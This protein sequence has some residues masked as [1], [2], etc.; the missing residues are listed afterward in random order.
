MNIKISAYISRLSALIII[1]I[2]SIVFFAFQD[3][4]FTLIRSVPCTSS[5]L[6]TDNLGNAYL[7][8]RNVLEKYDADGNLVKSFSNKSM[9]DISFAD[10][11]DPLKILLFYKAFQQIVFTDNM[12]APSG[13]T[14]S[15]EQLDYNQ[16]SL[17]CTS[18]NNGFWIYSQQNMELV[19]FDQNLQKSL[20]TGNI[21]QLSGMSI[22]PN[23]LTEQN[24]NVF[25]NDSANG[26]LVFDIYG[27]YSKT[28]PIKGL[29]RFQVSNDD[30]LYLSGNK[31]KSYNMKTL[32][33]V[34]IALPTGEIIDARTGKEKLYL[35]KQKSLDIYSVKK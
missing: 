16:T 6:T 33:E 19:R 7:I 23:F 5:F 35:L 9:A 14:I 25:L 13:N 2:A 31:L 18:H 1:G 4:G 34:E 26:I 10:A 15:L 27:T 3:S 17:V 8:K 12:L 29:L 22:N 32:E 24:N 21:T 20:Q 30:I 11:H 28:F